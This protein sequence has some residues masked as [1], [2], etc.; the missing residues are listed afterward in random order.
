MTGYLAR[1]AK[2][3]LAMITKMAAG[4]G[5]ILKLTQSQLCDVVGYCGARVTAWSQVRS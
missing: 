5:S 4:E 2:M 1:D 3:L